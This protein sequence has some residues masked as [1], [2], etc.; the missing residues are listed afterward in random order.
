LPAALSNLLTIRGHI[1]IPPIIRVTRSFQLDNINNVRAAQAMDASRP[2][3][4]GAPHAWRGAAHLPVAFGIAVLTIA[5]CMAPARAETRRS[6]PAAAPSR[7]S[8]AGMA[9]PGGGAAPHLPG[10]M[11]GA[12]LPGSMGGGAHLPSNI[13]GNRMSGGAGANVHLP[14]SMQSAHLPQSMQH[15]A[16]RSE[17]PATSGEAGRTATATRGVARSGET[18]AGETRAGE[19][20]TGDRRAEPERDARGA[21]Q[22]HRERG[23]ERTGHAEADHRAGSERPGE[24]RQEQA[25]AGER[26]GQ[27]AARPDARLGGGAR[28]NTRGLEEAMR[29]PRAPRP[30]LR[31]DRQR[32]PATDRAF[33]RAHAADFHTRAVR[34]FTP[35]ELSVWRGGRWHNEWH[36]GRRG[37]WWETNGVWYGYDEPVWPYPTEV[38]VLTVYDT[39]VVDGPDLAVEEGLPPDAPTQVADASAVSPADASATPAA[40]QTAAAPAIP[41]L[42][43]AP[44]G[45]YKCESPGGY[46]PGVSSCGASWE[47]VQ[48]APLPGEQ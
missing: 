3:I 1:A 26:A 32:D 17:R 24:R 23:D 45:W 11:G 42:P 37:W 34:D 43:P 40:D 41:P 21:E 4:R 39:P 8:F 48:N 6:A 33:V 44:P 29:L 7:P 2:F 9:R 25:R 35:R 12:H 5:F 20:R 18:R 10:N 22:A 38:A 36:Y 28:L 31:P 30:F 14:S 15:S 16:I 27:V 19:T 46:F 13:A 47:L